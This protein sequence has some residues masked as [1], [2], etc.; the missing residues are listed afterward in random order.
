MSFLTNGVSVLAFLYLVHC[1]VF[2]HVFVHVH[3]YKL[4]IV[5]GLP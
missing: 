1:E 4:K 3:V 2:I 5:T